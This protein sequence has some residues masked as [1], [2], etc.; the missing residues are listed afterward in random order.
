[1]IQALKILRT[2][3][4]VLATVGIVLPQ[5]RILAHEQTIS[6]KTT[7]KVLPPNTILDIRLGKDGAFTGR[8]INHNGNAV[9]GA[10]VVI[11]Q[12]KDEV[13]ESVTDEHGNF[14]VPN[15]KSGIYEVSCGATK[16]TY[17]AWTD[18]AAPPSAKPHSV[19]VLGENGARG[20]YGLTGTIVGENLGLIFLAATTG[21]ALA[22][23]IV[24]LQ[25][26][27]TADDAASKSP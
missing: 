7:V 6:S 13:G 23:L 4:V 3:V 2:A 27:R 12:G 15:L 1:M 21:L 20:Q 11:K 25:A 8:T 17:R 10:K 26:E 14:S 16:G 19:L 9:V 24:A 5:V 18:K 22:A